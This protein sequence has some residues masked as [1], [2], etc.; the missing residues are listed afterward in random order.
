M[1][2]FKMRAVCALAALALALVAGCGKSEPSPA[3]SPEAAPP[4]PAPEAPILFW[5]C[6]MHPQIRKPGPGQCPI[7]GMDLI[8][9]HEESKTMG[10]REYHPVPDATKL[11]QIETALVEQRFV[12]AVV[13]MVGKVEYDETRVAT[14]TAWVPGRLDR[15]FVDYTGVPV[16][17]GDHLV[18]MYSPELM[19]AQEELIQ[20]LQAVTNLR[21]SGIGIVRETSEATVQAAREKLR[22]WGLTAEQIAEVEKRGTPSD[23]IT[24][25][26]PIGGI[27]ILKN[28]LEGMYVQTGSPIYTIADLSRV[29]VKLDAYESD[30]AWL[31]YGQ[32]IEFTTVAYPGEPFTGTIAFIDPILDEKTRTV[33]VRVD[34]PNS[35]GRLKPGMFVHAVVRADI[36]AGGRV[37]NADLAGKW[38]C[39]MHPD[40]VKDGPGSCDICGMPLVRTESLGYV[41]ADLASAPKP[42]V[43]PASAPLVT[44]TR[45]VVYVERPGK[46]GPTYEGREVVLGPR[47]GDFYLVRS[48]IEEGERVVTR[49]N[50]KIDAYLQIQAKPSMMSPEGGAAAGGMHMHGGAMPA[51][52][53]GEPA[54][55]APAIP[56]E[57]TAQLAA[58]LP[59][60]GEVKS[61]LALGDLAGAKAV[62]DQLGKDV[63]AINPGTFPEHPAMLWKEYAMLLTN[64]SVEGKESRE[65]KVAA[66]VADRLAEDLGRMKAAFDLKV[67][68]AP[69]AL[70]PEARQALAKVVTEYFALQ[71]ALASD[72]KDLSSAAAGTLAK[73][74]A[75]TSPT[76][77]ADKDREFW[78]DQQIELEQSLDRGV[79]AADLAGLR[80]AFALASETLRVLARHFGSPMDGPLYALRCPMAFGGRGAMWLQSDREVR[81]P[82]FGAAMPKC[83]DVE[84]MI[85]LA[86]S[87]EGA[88][89]D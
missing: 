8:P 68:A 88:A 9:V 52:K 12:T 67:A 55:P 87:A 26:S 61:A 78:A 53:E 28:A 42:L 3:P 20:A 83:G 89:H 13:R 24:I 27:V 47:A 36:A 19:S 85:P 38:I 50:F 86:G 45:A 15:L 49:G 39:P 80:E 81:N 43:I 41:S 84:E 10:L 57:V 58:L 16:R 33:K 31:R 63:A 2:F 51:A 65:L 69:P 44:G 5:T 21:S 25:Y 14:I 54:P 72:Q 6:S 23:H 62:F 66:S 11:M 40:V 70:T 74:V 79:K 34:A 37:M 7:C 30:L 56:P 59:A 18:Y 1:H 32:K 77:F 35:D 64:D 82:Y 76:V 60:A 29:W 73:T 22:L 48:G 46:D 75:A 17:K 4:A 71:E